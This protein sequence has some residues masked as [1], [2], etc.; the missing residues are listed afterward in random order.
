MAAY[1]F[2]NSIIYRKQYYLE[3]F[4][5]NYLKMGRL[6]HEIGHIW[7]NQSKGFQTSLAAFTEHLKHKD[8]VYAHGPLTDNRSLDDF[9]YEQQCQI[10]SDYYINRYLEFDTSAYEV[11]IYKSINKP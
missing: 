5:E 9:R 8:R 2:G 7:A 10:L 3:D 4:S 1:V 6:V 11:T